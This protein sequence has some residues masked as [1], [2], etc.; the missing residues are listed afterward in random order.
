M[1]QRVE[2]KDAKAT[3]HR[4]IRKKTHDRKKE[5]RESRKSDGSR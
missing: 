2:P 3:Y 4:I 5:N 1:R